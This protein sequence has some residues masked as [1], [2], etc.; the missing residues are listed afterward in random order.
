M[1]KLLTILGSIMISTSGAAL[2]V[3]CKTP[4]TKQPTNSNENTNQNEPTRPSEKDKDQTD[5]KKPV[6]PVNPSSK[7]ENNQTK[8]TENYDP[9]TYKDTTIFNRHFV[10]GNPSSWVGTIHNSSFIYGSPFKPNNETKPNESTT[11]IEPKKP[12]DPTPSTKPNDNNRNDSNSNQSRPLTPLQ[13]SIPTN[14]PETKPVSPTTTW[15]SVYNDSA[16]GADI[17]LNPTKEQIEKEEKRL[18]DW[19]KEYLDKNKRENQALFDYLI[20]IEYDRIFRD[21]PTGA[22]INFY[23]TKEQIEAEN[24]KQEDQLKAILD[25]NYKDNFANLMAIKASQTIKE[26]FSDEFSDL[27][28]QAVQ[29]YKHHG[30]THARESAKITEEIF[31]DEFSNKVKE[32]VERYKKHGD[33]HARESAKATIELFSDEFSDL[34]KQ[35]VQ[36]YKHHGDTHA[37][38]SANAAE[39]LFNDKYNLVNEYKHNLETKLAK[40]N[41]EVNT[42]ILERTRIEKEYNNKEKELEELAT[43]NLV[44]LKKE[45]ETG[46]QNLESRKTE[47]ETKLDR[48]TLELPKLKDQKEKIKEEIKDSTELL[49]EAKLLLKEN[50]DKQVEHN[51]VLNQAKDLEHQID[52]INKQIESKNKLV[53]DNN[54]KEKELLD[55]EKELD[56][57]LSE[58][59]VIIKQLDDE[60]KLYEK[61]IDDLKKE[62]YDSDLWFYDY[63]DWTLWTGFN[64]N[65]IARLKNYIYGNKELKKE[66]PNIIKNLEKELEITKQQNIEKIKQ[67]K[68]QNTKIQAEISEITKSLEPLNAEKN[69]ID[70]QLSDINSEVVKTNKNIELYTNN[71]RTLEEEIT[72][73][74]ELQKQ[75]IA[76]IDQYT[77]DQLSLEKQKEEILN[78]IKEFENSTNKIILESKQQYEDE[79]LKLE[80]QAHSLESKE[81]EKIKEI[82]KT[83]AKLKE[84][85]K[86]LNQ[87]Y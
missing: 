61:I 78:S 83:I 2:V 65:K 47:N 66:V 39:K 8:P 74:S 34:V 22:D 70:K 62:T 13:P 87:K 36:R 59:K 82:E 45:Y 42:H 73:N 40:L 25:K 23:L 28:K 4:A 17:N 46:K 67:L 72:S 55:I 69:K 43:N 77:S 7:P 60:N 18:E 3:A 11:P 35:A 41:E 20:K 56:K 16:T 85:I 53:T 31:S 24:K 29:R 32:A 75:I 80:K 49:E 10:S 54:N 21:S 9:K 68:E 50:Q 63:G 12:V 14:K 5:P 51:K 38:E 33:T 19:V 37:R 64:H 30:D 86:L 76:Q 44:T 27:V 79:L 26:L 84:S 1:K 6:E 81:D 57:E 15:Y 48:I 71:L 52:S 58:E